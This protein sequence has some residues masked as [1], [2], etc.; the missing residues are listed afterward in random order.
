MGHRLEDEVFPEFV[1]IFRNE[2]LPLIQEFICGQ[3][4]D[5]D[6]IGLPNHGDQVIFQ[7]INIFHPRDDIDQSPYLGF[8]YPFHKSKLSQS[9]LIKAEGQARL[10]ILV[11]I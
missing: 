3:I 5:M 8:P 1:D 9:I 4:A 10:Q 7:L 2:N 11:V 6:K